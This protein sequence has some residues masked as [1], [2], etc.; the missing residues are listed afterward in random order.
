MSDNRFDTLAGG[1]QYGTD[2]LMGGEQV[3]F[4][5]LAGGEQH[6][7]DTLMGGAQVEFDL[8]AGGEQ[9]GREL[10]MSGEQGLTEATSD[11]VC[12]DHSGGEDEHSRDVRSAA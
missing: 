5:L 4:D 12:A 10:F 7:T 1:E 8:L 11:N 3:G 9:R 6:G 2:S